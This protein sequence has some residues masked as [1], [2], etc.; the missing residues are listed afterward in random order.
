MF[1]AALII[2][3]IS[4]LIGSGGILSLLV[5]LSTHNKKQAVQEYR[6][7]EFA[8][9]FEQAQVKISG[10]ET[11]IALTNQNIS[12]ISGKLGKLDILD[13][14]N[15]KLDIV[16]KVIDNVIPRPEAEAKFKAVEE[17]VGA[18]EEAVRHSHE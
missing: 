1:N 14:V 8:N 16:T 18:V 15:A 17:R 10:L 5:R 12:Y 9:K 3:L 2:S 7:E 11:Q 13:S 6:L 4:I